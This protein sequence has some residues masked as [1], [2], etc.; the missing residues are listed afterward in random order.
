M[1]ESLSS[2]STSAPWDFRPLRG[3]VR[4]LAYLGVIVLFLVMLEAVIGV[5]IF[6]FAAFS[7]SASVLKSIGKVLLWLAIVAIAFGAVWAFATLNRRLDL[8]RY[9]KKCPAGS[10]YLLGGS[11]LRSFSGIGNV[12]FSEN[13]MVLKGRLGPNLLWPLII[14]IVIDILSGLVILSGG[15]GI[16]I[17]GMGAIIILAIYNAVLKRDTSLSIEPSSVGT[18][19]CS[20]PIVKIRFGSNPVESLGV[21]TLLLPPD[22]RGEFFQRF[23]RLFPQKLPHTYREALE[24]K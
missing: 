3:I 22:Q 5:L 4:I 14:I 16:V 13:A 23:D 24:E 10:V 17:G 6:P 8:S 20:G 7:E 2:A 11:V 21:V 18:V 9:L 1:K 15:Q 12:I 19:R